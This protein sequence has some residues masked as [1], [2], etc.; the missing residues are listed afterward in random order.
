M[1][2]DI[3][4]YAATMAELAAAAGDGRAEVL[5]RRGLD[6]DRWA[7]IDTYWQARLSEAMD[8]EGDGVAELLSV[9]A[10]AYEVAQ[11]AQGEPIPIEQ[12]ALVTRLL[13]A[14]GD[15]RASLSRAGVTMAQYTRAT[16]HWSRRFADDPDLERRFDEAFRG[17]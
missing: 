9:Y 3:E 16:E 2:L 11:R 6:E 13:Q 12:F 14:T 5:A 17:G 1:D 8:E 7:E 10:A 4:A 15:I